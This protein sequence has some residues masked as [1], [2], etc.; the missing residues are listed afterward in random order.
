MYKKAYPVR[1][2]HQPSGKKGRQRIE[3]DNVEGRAE[4]REQV[5][6]GKREGKDGRTMSGGMA[7]VSSVCYERWLFNRRWYD[8][9][10]WEQEDEIP[11][12][13]VHIKLCGLFRRIDRDSTRNTKDSRSRVWVFKK[14]CLVQ[15][16][17][18]ASTQHPSPESQSLI[19]TIE[20]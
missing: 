1:M 20:R 19:H 6:G 4:G 12:L 17:D 13:A 10:R 14:P 3:I 15:R 5:E 2:R 18:T 16:L 9:S 11:S 7:C 8:R